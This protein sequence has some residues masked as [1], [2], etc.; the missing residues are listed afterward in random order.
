M[1]ERVCTH[2]DLHITTPKAEENV[3]YVTESC[4]YLISVP[5]MHGW[6]ATGALIFTVICIAT[7]LHSFEPYL[8]K[9]MDIAN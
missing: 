2:E 8:Y 3:V 6:L 9:K 1:T 7:S 4:R 5:L